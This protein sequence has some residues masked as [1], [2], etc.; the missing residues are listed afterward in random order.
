MFFFR[1]PKLLMQGPP[2]IHGI[3]RQADPLNLF[4]VEEPLAIGQGMQGH[5]ADGRLVGLCDLLRVIGT[6]R[7]SVSSRLG[8]G[9]LI[10]VRASS[11]ISVVAA[12]VGARNWEFCPFVTMRAPSARYEASDWA[13]G[14]EGVFPPDS[15]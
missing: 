7:Q 10:V 1:L 9:G 15:R 13:L 2:G 8:Q 12:S 3:I 6:G 14:A 11:G 4:Q 5:H